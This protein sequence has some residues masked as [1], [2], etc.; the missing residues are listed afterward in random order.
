MFVCKYDHSK[1]CNGCKECSGGHE[2]AVEC[3]EC[4]AINPEYL[5]MRKAVIIG[6][7]ECIKQVSTD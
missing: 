1:D 6:C 4:G 3:D 5:Y 2:P 7:S